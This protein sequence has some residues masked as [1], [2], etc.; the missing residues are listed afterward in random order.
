MLPT[1]RVGA[2]P[3]LA[4][5]GRD[6]QPHLLAHGP[7]QE[8][9]DGMR[10]PAGGFHQFL[11]GDAARPLQQVQD[12][13]GLAAVA[14]LGLGGLGFLRAL[15]RFLGRGGLL[16]RLALGGRNGRATWR[17]GGLFV[18]FRLLLAAVAGAVAVS[19]AI[20]F[21]LVSP[22]LAVITAVTTWIT[23]LAQKRK[24]ILRDAAGDG[25]AM[26][27]LSRQRVARRTELM[28]RGKAKLGRKKEEA[29]L[30]LLSQRNT[31]E[32]ARAIGV[33]PRTLYRWLQ[34]PDFSAAYREAK[35]SAFSQAI[36]RLQTM[37]TAAV[38]TLGK[39]MVDQAAPAASRVRAASSVLDFAAK[40]IEIE[41][42]EARL[43]AL[44]Q[45]A[46]DAKQ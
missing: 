37:T 10:L 30:A 12:L 35:R 16:P 46:E 29:I 43:A 19:S 40:A 25:M 9:A 7:G 28:A 22:L 34:E 38:S 26:G 5:G 32:A 41:D 18:G 13:G 27:A 15:G 14:R 2:L 42:L 39:V 8:A 31:E 21:M 24:A 3:V 4:L 11:G 6:G 45:S 20:V 44:E 36:A 33:T 17:T 1:D 23:L